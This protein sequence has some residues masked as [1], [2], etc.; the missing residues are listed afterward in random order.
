MFQIK[1]KVVKQL[2]VATVPELWRGHISPAS[3]SITRSPLMPFPSCVAIHG[4]CVSDTK[5]SDQ[6]NMPLKITTLITLLFAWVPLHRSTLE[7]E[8]KARW[9]AFSCRAKILGLLRILLVQLWNQ[10]SSDKIFKKLNE[11]KYL[12]A[13]LLTLA[14]TKFFYFWAVIRCCRFFS[15]LYVIFCA[16]RESWRGRELN[17]EILLACR[18]GKS[19]GGVSLN[20]A[21]PPPKLLSNAPLQVPADAH[22]HTHACTQTFESAL[23]R[24][25]HQKAPQVISFGEKNEDSNANL[26]HMIFHTALHNMLLD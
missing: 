23:P 14:L 13:S 4:M 26:L 20:C 12:N 2:K 6:L 17:G 16:E 7:T 11:Y 8:W 3:F 25:L 9:E 24:S 1:F 10:F 19:K 5:V 18:I 22:S 21:Q 15:L